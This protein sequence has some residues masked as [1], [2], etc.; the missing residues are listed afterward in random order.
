[1]PKKK[2]KTYKEIMREIMKPKKVESPK[3]P[4]VGGG[5]P[6]KSP[7]NLNANKSFSRYKAVYK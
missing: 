2:S 1:M 4:A 7:S 5:V 3:I 6:E